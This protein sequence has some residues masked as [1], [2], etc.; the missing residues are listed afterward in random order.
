MISGWRYW[1]TFDINYYLEHNRDV[2][3]A[4]GNDYF[5]AFLHFFCNGMAEGRQA[6]A[7]FNLQTYARYNPDVV[8]AYGNDYKQYYLHY[9]YC[10]YDEGRRAS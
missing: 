5:K 6:S 7:R 10:G 1:K 2:A 3:A 8:N 4:Y 9:I